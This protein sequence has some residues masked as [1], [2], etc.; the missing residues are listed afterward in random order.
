MV[1]LAGCSTASDSGGPVATNDL[2]AEVSALQ[3]LPPEEQESQLR[4]Q[5]A[6]VEGQML[7]LSGLQEELG[8]P[9]QAQ[10]AYSAMTTALVRRTTQS[11]GTSGLMGRFGAAVGLAEP[12]SLGGMIFAGWMIGA[13]AAEGIVSSTNDAKPGA[14][15]VRDV[16]ND[17]G[18]SS[19]SSVVHEASLESTSIDATVETTAGG[20][21]GTLRFKMTINPCPDAAGVFTAKASMTTSATTGG[22]RT[23]SNSSVDIALTGRVDDDAR[24]AGYDIT[25]TSQAAEFGSGN[26]VWAEVT[27]TISFAGGEVTGASRTFGRSAGN[28]P[29]GFGAQ[30][31]NL[32]QLF[33]LMVS[34]QMLSAAQKG[35][36]SGR[37]VA[38]DPTTDPGKRTGLAPGASVTILAAPRS[39]VDGRP[40]GGTVTA[41]LA[42]GTSVDPAGS[43][44]SA[45]ARFAYLA[46]GERDKSAT[47][48]LEARSRRGV[49]KA[50]IDF[51]TRPPAYTA[52]GQDEVT[53]SGTVASITAPFTVDGTFPGGRATFRFDGASEDGGTL[54]IAGGGSGAR[55]TGRG[56]YTVSEGENGVL[57]L[58]VRARACVDVSGVCRSAT[59]RI[60]LT[61]QR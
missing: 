44:V 49:A 21:T 20:V 13:L 46:P 15:P 17:N 42:G 50:T 25:T 36:E 47:V 16:R 54:R 11:R 19:A 61:P 43:K 29:E 10:V 40:T 45:D 48:S 6:D 57:F 30:W 41:T 4:T 18:G 53:F 24:L 34:N 52:S 22:G 32:G 56:T 33:A 58:D 26:N 9:E 27:D 7:A 5:S 1:V 60:T 3:A 14:E 59:H 12:P 31:A 23:G 39:K 37:C 55:L 2:A 8:G 28:V 38:L 35:W 51:D